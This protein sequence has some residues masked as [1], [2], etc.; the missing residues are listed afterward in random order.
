VSTSAATVALVV[1][2]SATELC[3]TVGAP[4]GCVVNVRSSDCACPVAFVASRR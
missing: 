4:T 2:S 1:A 3:T